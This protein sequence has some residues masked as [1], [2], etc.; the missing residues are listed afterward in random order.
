MKCVVEN[1]CGFA[2]EGCSGTAERCTGGE[3]VGTSRAGAGVDGV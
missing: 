3:R 2:A 1:S